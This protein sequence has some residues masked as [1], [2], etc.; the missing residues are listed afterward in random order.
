MVRCLYGGEDDFVDLTLGAKFGKFMMYGFRLTVSRELGLRDMDIDSSIILYNYGL[1]HMF[2]LKYGLPERKAFKDASRLMR[3][4]LGVLDREMKALFCRGQSA[5]SPQCRDIYAISK[6]IATNYSY[7]IAKRGRYSE[8][9]QCYD[10]IIGNIEQRSEYKA[11]FHYAA[12]A[13]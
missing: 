10:Y 7:L 9:K 12:A 3:M 4:A 6:V 13:A 11:R 8:A 2:I 5:D 1:S